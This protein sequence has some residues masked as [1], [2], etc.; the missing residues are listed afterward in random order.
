MPEPDCALPGYRL[1]FVSPHPDDEA[2]FCGGTLAKYAR[3]GVTVRVLHLTTGCSDFTRIN[4]PH[5]EDLVPYG[6]LGSAEQQQVI[7]LR[8]TEAG[9][10]A[11]KL[12]ISS[13]V[14]QPF[15]SRSLDIFACELIRQEIEAF[16]PH[17]V[18]SL[19]E[20]GT[21]AH[22]DHSWSAVLTYR[23]LRAMIAQKWDGTLPRYSPLSVPPFAFRRYFTFTL[24]G[25]AQW[26]EKWSE[27]AFETSERTCID[28]D[29]VVDSRREA[30]FT[31]Q[32]QQHLIAFF[33]RVGL[34]HLSH[35]YYVERIVLGN[36]ARG[37]DNLFASWDDAPEHAWYSPLPQ[38]PEQY[39][40]S[41]AAWEEQFWRVIQ[42]ASSE[43]K[44]EQ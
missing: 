20:A 19:N 21:T 29:E 32:T 37:K 33:E 13:I 16:D 2:I 1:L 40:F 14:C 18:I 43:R 6:T 36:S 24:P 26:L 15:A 11:Q 9:Q 39:I 31:Y 5:R 10:A 27:I 25:C 38:E 17:V 12:G 28:V 42:A 41:A 22:R 4:F 3:A 35:E 8:R 44:Q 30:A 34:L 23:A 7:Q